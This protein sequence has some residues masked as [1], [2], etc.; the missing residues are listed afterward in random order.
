MSEATSRMPIEIGADPRGPFAGIRVVDLSTIVS[1]PLCGQILGDL[2]ADVI[3]I[4]T[5]T[6][7]SSRSMGGERKGNIT[8]FFAQMNRNK[9]SVVLDLKTAEGVDAFRRLAKTADVV[10]ENFRPGVMERLGVGYETLREDNPSLVYGAISGFGDIGPYAAQPAYDMVIQALSGIGEMIGSPGAPKLVNNLLADKTA[11]LSA[12][13]A[14]AAA[15]FSR[16]RTGEGQRVD[17]PMYDAFASFL[18]LDRIGAEAFGSPAGDMSAVGEL[19]FRLWETADGRVVILMIEDHQF[20]AVCRII[21]HPEA[22]ADPRFRTIVDRFVNA[23]ALIEFLSEEVGKLTTA[24]IVAGAHAEGT[25]LAPIHDA[26]EFAA[27]PQVQASGIVFP[28]EHEVGPIPS[29][30]QPARFSETPATVRR[31]SPGLGEHTE[32]VLR[33][34]GLSDEEI[35]KIRGS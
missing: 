30:R 17:L 31:P 16:E 22:G 12:A 2:G 15:L 29:L 20:Q 6:G 26:E 27:D 9:R 3:K 11:G 18:H 35:S 7:D 28:I 19:L 8:G 23:A 33:E 21:G 13:Y 10:L 25:P 24:E 34:A 1:G 32:E 14:V 4:E 5:P